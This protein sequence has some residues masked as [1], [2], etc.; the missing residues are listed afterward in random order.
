MLPSTASLAAEGPQDSSGPQVQ[1]EI[2]PGL[3]GDLLV[4]DEKAGL[5]VF[6]ALVSSYVQCRFDA[7]RHSC[8]LV[9]MK[10][11]TGEKSHKNDG[12]N[13]PHPLGPQP[14][15]SSFVTV[16]QVSSSRVC[17]SLLLPISH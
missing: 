11:Q 1:A 10:P 16:R 13:G 4:L 15:V 6:S 2:R 14:G 7:D 12:E 9:V 3:L 8:L 17:F 5:L